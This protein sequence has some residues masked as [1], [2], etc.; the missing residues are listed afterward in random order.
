MI[1]RVLNHD[2]MSLKISLIM[3]FIVN[4]KFS[5]G[6]HIFFHFRGDKPEYIQILE[7]PLKMAQSISANFLHRSVCK[8][9]I[10][11]FE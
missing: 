7:M 5:Y 11:S 1:F 4:S 6:N 2:D 9:I 8:V 3:N 10:K